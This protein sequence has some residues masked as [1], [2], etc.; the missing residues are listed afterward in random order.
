MAQNYEELIAR[1]ADTAGIP[2]EEVN[3]K[4]EAKKEKLSGLISKEGAAQIV[5]AELGINF[6]KQTVKINQIIQG[7]RR[8]N[9]TAKIIH[10]NEIR[11]YNKNG[12]SGKVLNLILAD[13]TGGLR[14]VLWDVNHIALF[15]KK[16]LGKGDV[17]EINNGNLRGGEIHLTG[18][19]D[20]KKS[21]KKIEN[22]KADIT[23]ET[24][25]KTIIEIKPQDKVRIR[26][27]I[28]Q[29]FEPKTFEVCPEC[30]KKPET[31]NC[32]QHGKITPKVRALLTAVIDD[33]SENTRAV[34]FSE[35]LSKLGINED[36]ANFGEVRETI[37]GREAY[38]SGNV[39]T[40]KYF[41]NEEIIIT[42]VEDI[43]IE[44]LITQLEGKKK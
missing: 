8:L 21:N 3:K 1:I 25:E 11:E 2:V 41:N 29:M 19:S 38:Y 14:C 36:L 23:K 12:R 32:A 4:V 34:F 26:A 15:E 22:V 16:Q 24:V 33:G 18:F 42:D 5:A 30:G 43:K 39:R 20:I 35:Q 6:E 28:V 44:E 13:D 17:I 40:N 27:I 37:L 31:S 10:Q 7:M 9:L